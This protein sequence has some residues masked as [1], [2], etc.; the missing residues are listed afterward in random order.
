M[1]GVPGMNAFATLAIASVTTL[2]EFVDMNLEDKINAFGALIG[3]NRMV[4][5]HRISVI[6]FFIASYATSPSIYI[7]LSFCG[8]FVLD[9]HQLRFL[10]PF[11]EILFDTAIR[12]GVQR[13][14]T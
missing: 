14:C 4:S 12:R 8:C 7:I 3:A 2:Q 6:S 1:S 9:A 11:V 5:V 10:I 13:N